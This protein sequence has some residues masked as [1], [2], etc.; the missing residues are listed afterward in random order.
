MGER[1]FKQFCVIFIL[2]L[3]LSQGFLTKGPLGELDHT[4][5]YEHT[6]NNDFVIRICAANFSYQ[7][8]TL[9]R[10]RMVKTGACGC[11]CKA[12]NDAGSS[13]QGGLS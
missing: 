9:N 2:L 12:L 11:T 6:F 13:M 8:L 4:V 3:S 1:A 10:A 5:L 7:E